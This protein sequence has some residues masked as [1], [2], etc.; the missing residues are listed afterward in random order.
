VLD[1]GI[2]RLHQRGFAQRRDRIGWPPGTQR[3]SSKSKQRRYL[4]SG[5]A[6]IQQFGHDATIL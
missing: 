2:E 1:D 3:L 5:L 6:W 4:S